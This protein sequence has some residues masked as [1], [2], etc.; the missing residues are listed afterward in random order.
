MKEL[1][2]NGWLSEDEKEGLNGYVLYQDECSG[3]VSESVKHA[4]KPHTMLNH[5]TI[6]SSS[7]Q[8]KPFLANSQTLISY[9]DTASSVRKAKWARHTGLSGIFL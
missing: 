7:Y 6:L 4:N 8:K 5:S 9:D 2:E 1:V 3:V